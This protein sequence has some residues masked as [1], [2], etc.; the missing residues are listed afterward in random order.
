MWKYFSIYS[1]W[2]IAISNW[3][4]YCLLLLFIHLSPFKGISHFALCLDILICLFSVNLLS[5]FSKN[6]CHNVFQHLL[7]DNF[8]RC[9]FTLNLKILWRRFAQEPPPGP[10][11]GPTC[12]VGA[13]STTTTLPIH[14]HNQYL[15]F[16]LWTFLLNSIFLQKA[17]TAFFSEMNPQLWNTPCNSAIRNSGI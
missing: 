11:P 17:V 3:L 12:W 8:S 16:C 6:N 15:H 9:F 5:Y 4:Y 1:T 13:Y 14:H 10:C 7:N 2:D